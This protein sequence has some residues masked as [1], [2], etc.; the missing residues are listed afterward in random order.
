MGKTEQNKMGK[1]SVNKLIWQMGL[2]MILSMILQALYNIIDTAFVINMGSDGQLA[3]LALTYAFPIQILLISVGVGTGIGINALLSRY[4]GERNSVGAAKVAGNGIFLS[5]VI[6][7]VFL[8]FGLFGSKWFI[9]I[10]AN[11]NE[12]IIE[13]G[14]TYLFITCT[15]SLGAIGFTVY[16]RFLQATGKTMFST[17]SQVIGALIN[18]LLDYVFIYICNW[19]VAGA[20]YATVIGQFA[21]LIVA[22]LLHYLTNKE[23]NG[24]LVYLKPSSSIIKGIYMIGLPAAIMQALLSVMMLGMNLILGT[25]STNT[26]LI[27]GTF[28]IYFKIQQFALFAAF[29][30]SNTLIT[31][32]SFNY[33]MKNKERVTDTLKYGII[34]S[35]IISL[36][37]TILFE[38]LAGPLSKL[39]GMTSDSGEEII[40]SRTIAIRIAAIGYV[41]MGISISIQGVMQALRYTCKPL[42]I[43]LCRLVIF[44][45]PVAYLFT[46]SPNAIT[47]V[48]WTFPIS[49][50]ITAIISLILIINVYKTKIMTISSVK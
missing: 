11:G 17:L 8:L 29:G 34:N 35:I 21:S 48:W 30:L 9:S 15:L 39:F 4:L 31:L 12:K 20:A 40:N 50:G 28:G 45:F 23:I 10:Q 32:T 14:Q 41:F 3:N 38:A 49:E 25:C 43:S 7:L 6:Y 5:L 2:P 37:I 16:E 19:G 24:S 27:Q 42:L 33:G 22:M 47:L 44:V 26:E 13:M 1:T 46:L 36:S 18:I